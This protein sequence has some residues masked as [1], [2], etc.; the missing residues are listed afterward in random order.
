MRLFES[1]ADFIGDTPVLYPGSFVDV[2][3]SLVFDSV[4]DVDNSDPLNKNAA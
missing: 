3:A 1:V 4:T 2:A